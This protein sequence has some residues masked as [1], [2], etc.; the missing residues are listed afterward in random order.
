[1]RKRDSEFLYITCR[2]LNRVNRIHWKSSR[3]QRVRQWERR[4]PGKGFQSSSCLSRTLFSLPLISCSWVLHNLLWWPLRDIHLFFFA[5]LHW[6]MTSSL[7]TSLPM[8]T[9]IL[10]NPF[11]S[12]CLFLTP[13][14]TQ[15]ICLPFPPLFLPSHKSSYR[16]PPPYFYQ[17][18]LLSERLH[19]FEREEWCLSV[20]HLHEGKERKIRQKK[21]QF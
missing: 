16:P 11:S 6:L 17:K 21:S 2:S 13:I 10:L 5:F 18:Y 4:Y 9:V 12:F 7:Y 19:C 8:F 20:V 3:P 14:L 1:M 15:R